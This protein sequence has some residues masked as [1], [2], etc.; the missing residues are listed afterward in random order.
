[1]TQFELHTAA[2]VLFG[3]K[4]PASTYI[5]KLAAALD[6][7]FSGVEKWWY[8]TRK[9]IPGSVG[10]ALRLLIEKAATS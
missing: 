3:P 5:G 1:M 10:V 9:R 2:L 7:S 6:M 4:L 8:G